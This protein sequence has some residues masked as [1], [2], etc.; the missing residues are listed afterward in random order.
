[1]RIASDS[2]PDGPGSRQ[3]LIDAIEARIARE[4]L[5]PT[6]FGRAAVGDGPFPGRLDRGSGMRLA[7]DGKVPAFPGKK[8]VGPCFLRGIEA[9]LRVTRTK[10]HLLGRRALGDPGFVLTF[11]RGRSPALRTSDRVHAFMAANARAAER[12]AVEG[13]LRRFRPMR[14]E[15]RRRRWTARPFT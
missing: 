8:P 11:S 14:Q 2:H 12:A 4:K 1:M 7:T 9:W 3:V 15:R 10:T 6:G 13:G 5:T